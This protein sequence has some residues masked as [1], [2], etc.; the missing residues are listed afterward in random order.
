MSAEK[1]PD[2]FEVKPTRIGQRIHGAEVVT[3]AA[4]A[5]LRGRPLLV[6]VARAG[7]RG[8]IRGALSGMRFVEGRDFLC[9]A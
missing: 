6:S 2:T 8:E 4:L 9:C 5:E 1:L 7:P 3:P